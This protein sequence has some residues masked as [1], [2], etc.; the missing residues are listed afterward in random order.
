MPVLSFGQL[1]KS[2][3]VSA[4]PVRPSGE[5]VTVRYGRLG[6]PGQLQVK[7]FPSEKAAQQHLAK[8]VAQKQKKGYRECAVR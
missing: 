3:I 7:D 5:S 4:S 8:L 1:P 6:T 2:M